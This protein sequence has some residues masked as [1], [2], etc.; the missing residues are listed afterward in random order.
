M[1]ALGLTL[2]ACGTQQA[3]T[4]VTRP[5]GEAPLGRPLGSSDAPASSPGGQSARSAARAFLTSY[6]QISY[7]H[8]DLQTLRRATPALRR[9]L[10]AQ[11]AR[12]PPGVRKRTPR[13]T[14]LELRATQDGQLRAMAT[15]DDGD[16]APYLVFATLARRDGDWQAVALG[17]E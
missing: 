14:E 12:V 4:G 1:L 6:L 15:I 7:G 17:G 8:A 9:T 16:I 5:D 13:I 10:R 11:A 3:T 2:A